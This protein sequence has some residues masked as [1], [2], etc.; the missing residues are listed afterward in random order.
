MVAL[1]QINNLNYNSCVCFQWGK[2][3][4]K[5]ILLYITTRMG[6]MSLATPKEGKDLKQNECTFRSRIHYRVKVLKQLRQRSRNGTYPVRL[7]LIHPK[8]ENKD[9]QSYINQVIDK[10][11]SNILD[12]LIEDHEKKL[13]VDKE[14]LQT[15]RVAK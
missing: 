8:M 13:T 12:V 5:S 7:N 4:I 3:Y 1:T 6:K 14:C 9:A 11:R 2:R 10:A 15:L